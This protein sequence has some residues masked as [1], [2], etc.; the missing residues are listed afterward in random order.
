M[1][2]RLLFTVFLPL[3]F[4]SFTGF[5]GKDHKTGKKEQAKFSSPL[6]QWKYKRFGMFVHWGVYSVPAGEWHGL[7]CPGDYAEHIMRQFR[8][9]VA[10]YKKEVIEKFNPVKFNADEWVRIL[11][12]AGMGYMVITAKHHDGFA[13]YDSDVS[14]YNIVKATPFHRDPMIELRRACKKAGVLFGFYYSHAQDWAD[15]NG[16]KNTWDYPGEPS[17]RNWMKKDT[18]YYPRIKKYYYSKAIPQLQELIRKYDP[19]IIWF[20]TRT[21]GPEFLNRAVIDSV[22]KLKPDLIINSRG[23]SNYKHSYAS[24]NDRPVEFPKRKDL[25]EAIPTTNSSYGHF[26]WDFTYKSPGYFI[27][28][29]CKAASAGGNLLLNIGPK[30]DGTID[31][32][33]QGILGGIGEWMK[34][35]GSA[36]KGTEASPLPTQSFGQITRK[37]DTL[38]CLINQWPKNGKLVVGGLTSKV[39]KARLLTWPEKKDWPVKR[40]NDRDVEISL[41]KHAQVR[42]VTVLA[43]QCKKVVPDN[44]PQLLLDNIQSNRLHVIDATLNGKGLKYAGG[45][46]RSD[47]LKGWNSLNDFAEW[48]MRNNTPALFDMYISY[49]AL[50]VSDGNKYVVQVDGKTYP[51]TVIVGQHYDPLYVGRVQ[52]PAG[53]HEMV[54]KAK[55]NFKQELFRLRAL[56]LKPVHLKKH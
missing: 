22:L 32:V 14:D 7:V 39:E 12:N 13:M 51:Q 49:D 47:F 37:G 36:I 46:W 15:S 2:K 29:L 19:D 20:D 42:P 21:W 16:V 4:L 55:N 9:P 6:Q 40:L 34:T 44:S 27:E 23:A 33:D 52:L 45:N 28:L 18:S 50:P 5:S 30:S 24:T 25:W 48:K 11:K 1:M 35:N 8:I 56:Y 54:V 17:Q 31:I 3:I 38:Y 41:P 53:Q 10:V 43:L 26:K